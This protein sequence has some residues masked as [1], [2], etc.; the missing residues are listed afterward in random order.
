MFRKLTLAASRGLFDALPC[1]APQK[2]LRADIAQ[3][4]ENKP[5]HR[6]TQSAQ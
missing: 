5:Q 2:D 4:T 6:L 1:E 3:F